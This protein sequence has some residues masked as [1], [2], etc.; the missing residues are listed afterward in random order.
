MTMDRTYATLLVLAALGSGSAWAQNHAQLTINGVHTTVFSNGLIGPATPNGNGMEAPAGTGRSPLF[1]SGIWI[2]GNSPDNQLKFAAHLYGTP[3]ER[4][5]FPGPLTIDGTA[6]I[7]PEVSA[8]YDQVWSVDQADV[9]L[10]RAYFDCLADP[11]C[12]PAI[13]FPGGYTIPASFLSWPAMGDVEAGQD[14]YLAPFYDRD[15]DGVYAPVNGDHPCVL[16]EQA[17]YTIFNDRLDVHTQSGGG[18]IGLEVHMMPFA[19]TSD[20]ALQHTAFVHYTLI[21][22][23]TQTLSDVR[24]GHFADFDLGCGDDDVVGTDVGRSM[25][26][27]ANGDDNDEDCVGTAGYGQQPPAFGMAILKGP[28]L[29]PDGTD[30][31]TDPAVPAFNGYGYNDGVIDNERHGLSSSMYF[32]RSGP[33][34]MSDPAQPFHYYNHLRN[35][36]K[37]NMM[38]MY[39]G[40]GYSTGPNDIPARFAFPS[41][42]DPLA[43]G[44]AGI[45]QAPWSPQ[46][47]LGA[48]HVDPRAV[49][50]M[51]PIVL[52]PG[53]R[54][55]LLVA[56][57][58]ASAGSG[59]AVASVAALQER[60]DSIRTMALNIPGM[61]SLDE[62]NALGC[63][64]LLASVDELHTRRTALVMYPNP[65]SDRLTIATGSLPAGS[66]IQVLDAQGRTV[67]RINSTGELSHVN[68]NDL[69]A[70]LY[71]ILVSDGSGLTTG[72]FIKE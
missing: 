7:S 12:D 17:L 56:Y 5:F 48:G 34:E 20:P 36:W 57:V 41:D 62:A 59:G 47:D 61:F 3:G 25:V 32:L 37:D 31:T 9:L 64:D 33:A 30:N 39:G 54:I 10:H 51:G 38:F 11:G 35:L 13:A 60:V 27:V 68:V 66:P 23:G 24:I 22:R 58:Y 67:A 53:E 49:A 40:D 14:T 63:S 69:P 1:T 29:D 43:L 28:L 46:V 6:T 65:V 55:T 2:G 70:G 42:T 16:G 45:P 26:Y 71:T 15:G 19:Y 52:E 4:D 21:N 44:T 72:R 18:A 50:S 8:T